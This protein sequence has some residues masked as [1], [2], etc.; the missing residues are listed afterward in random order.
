[1]IQRKPNIV[2]RNIHGSRFLI[3]ITA[4]FNNDKCSLY[5][6]NEIGE[7]IWNNIDGKSTNED[8][9]RRLKSAINDDVEYALILDDVNEFVDILVCQGF[10]ERV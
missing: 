9:A 5:E 7:F 3:D 6:L 8:I 2:F 10:V 1:M 4:N